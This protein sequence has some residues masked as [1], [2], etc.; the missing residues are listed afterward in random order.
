MSPEEIAFRLVKVNDLYGDEMLQVMCALRQAREI[1][2][3]TLHLSGLNAKQTERFFSLT[4]ADMASA[5]AWLATPGNHL[6]FADSPYYPAPLR[7]I[8]DYPAVLCVRGVWRCSAHPSLPSSVAA[9][10]RTMA[11]D[12]GVIFVKRWRI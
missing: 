11:N 8:R 7:A 1:T 9:S 4:S 10:I 3:Q 2:R 6:L 5:M 12:G